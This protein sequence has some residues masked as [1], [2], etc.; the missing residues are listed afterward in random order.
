MR[1]PTRRQARW[2]LAAIT[3][4][5]AAFRFYNLAWGAPYYHFHMDE[6]FVL[7]PADT[8]RNDVRAAAMGPKFFMYPPLMMYLINIVFSGWLAPVRGSICGL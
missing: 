8:L 3:A 4:A 1:S 6:H 7:G 5:G 2:I